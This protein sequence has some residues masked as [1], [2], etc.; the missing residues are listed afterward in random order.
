MKQYSVYAF[1]LDGVL[2]LDDV[3]VGSA[4]EAVNALKSG[5]RKVFFLTNNSTRLPVEYQK[6]L[7]GMGVEGVVEE[8]IITSGV[9]TAGYFR[10]LLKNNPD[11][12][13]V[14]CVT[15]DA[16][17][18]LLR[19]EGVK[20]A[21]NN[22]Y[23]SVDYVVVGETDFNRESLYYPV[24]AIKH[25]GAGFIA[26]NDDVTDAVE[27]GESKPVAGALVKYI[28]ACTQ[29]K[30]VVMGKPYGR[31]FKELLDRLEVE[32]TEVLIVGDRLETDIKGGLDA[33]LETALVET[34]VHAREDVEK[35]GIQPTYVIEELTELLG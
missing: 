21:S 19:E 3:V 27:G 24:N 32:P 33:G 14:L 30:P 29:V 5:K 11:K 17:K 18:I 1:D 26:T 22:D 28:E 10:E 23:R 8:D 12:N 20:I 35:F 15:E 16:V 9:V 25:Y 31:M 4:V 13:R 6:R 34:G 7:S 2:Y